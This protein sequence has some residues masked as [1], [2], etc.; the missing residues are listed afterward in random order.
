MIEPPVIVETEDVQVAAIPLVVPRERI[1]EVMGPAIQEVH[2]AL[3][4]QGIAPAGPWLTHHRRR[5]GAT[6][7]LEVCVP[8][9]RPVAAVGRVVPSRIP[10]ARVART[11]YHG[12]YEGLAAAWPELEAWLEREGLRPTGTLWEVYR[13]GPES[14][15]DASAWRTELNRP[16]GR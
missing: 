1:R 3:R 15:P 14:T 8:V 9:A 2:E 16:V 10:A 7:D 12:P 4:G 5:P 11:V 13:L 6:F